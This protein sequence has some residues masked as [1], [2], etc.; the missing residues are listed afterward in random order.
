MDVVYLMHV[1]GKWQMSGLHQLEL[2]HDNE[3]MDYMSK[4]DQQQL[5]R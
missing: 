1:E 4:E 2:D 3:L 5:V